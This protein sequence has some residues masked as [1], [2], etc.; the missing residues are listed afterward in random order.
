MGPP[1]VSGSRGTH[2]VAESSLDLVGDAGHSINLEGHPALSD[3]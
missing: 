3:R 2:D 1:L